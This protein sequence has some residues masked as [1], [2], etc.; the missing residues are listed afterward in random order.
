MEVAVSIASC[1]SIHRL[2]N[3]AH[4]MFGTSVGNGFL[5]LIDTGLVSEEEFNCVRDDFSDVFIHI[6][7]KKVLNIKRRYSSVMWEKV[8]ACLEG[9]MTSDSDIFV[10]LDDD[11]FLNPH[12]FRFLKKIYEENP[13]VDYVSLLRG[14]GVIVDRSNEVSLSG[15]RFFRHRSCLGGALTARW[16][17]FKGDVD[18]FF[19]VNCVTGED[20]GTGGMFDQSF[21]DYLITNENKHKV[22]YT[23]RDFSLIQHCNLHSIYADERKD[24]LSH[25]YAVNFDPRMNPFDFQNVR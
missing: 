6:E 4:S 13:Q 1:G 21:F 24:L 12:A 25:M 7:S 2:R 10:N 15:F 11:M 3:F 5:S 18:G 14:P 17:V 9:E 22:V 20:A 23:T 16:S 8:Q 19:N